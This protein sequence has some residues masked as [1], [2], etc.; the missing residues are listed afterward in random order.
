M[1]CKQKL[2]NRAKNICDNGYC[3]VCDEAMKEVKKNTE[4]VKKKNNM[5]EVHVD[6]ELLLKMHGKLVKGEPVDQKDVSSL[7]LAGIIKILSQCDFINTLEEK[8]EKL[9][10][11]NLTN[12]FRLESIENWVLK[13]SEAI[14]KV[15]KKLEIDIKEIKDKVAAYEVT[16]QTTLKDLPKSMF[17]CKECGKTFTKNCELENHLEEHVDVNKFSCK[18][19]NKEFC[20]NWRLQKHVKM[21]TE[22]VRMCKYFKDKEV[23]PFERIGCMFGHGELVHTNSNEVIE[24][25]PIEDVEEESSEECDDESF[26]VDENQCH[27]TFDCENCDFKSESYNIYFEHI[28]V[29]HEYGDDF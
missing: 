13:Q 10:H 19:C 29:A 27:R 6:L 26:V 7:L 8:I 22:S 12:K 18:T 14:D 23:C 16:P 5:N 21:H 2:C 3:N 28:N 11:E 20:L 4:Q 17:K 25:D 1:K 9:E 15:D 24:E